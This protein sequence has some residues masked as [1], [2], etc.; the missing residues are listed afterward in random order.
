MLRNCRNQ[1]IT[2]I[3]GW[4]AAPRVNECNGDFTTTTAFDVSE[5]R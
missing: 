1:A 2:L 3:E 4:A 5:G